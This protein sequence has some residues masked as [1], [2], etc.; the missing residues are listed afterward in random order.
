MHASVTSTAKTT[1]KISIAERL[2]LVGVSCGALWN[3]SDAA[4]G[5]EG[6][7]AGSGT[8]TSG[9]SSDEPGPDPARMPSTLAFGSFGCSVHDGAA[10]ASSTH[11]RFRSALFP[12]AG[13]GLAGAAAAAAAAKAAGTTPSAV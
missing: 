5:A 10:G 1:R 6:L 3:R 8:A 12:V 7:G 11:E 4:R 2:R 9:A 13:R